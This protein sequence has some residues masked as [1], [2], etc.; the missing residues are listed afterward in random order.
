MVL[1][2]KIITIIILVLLFVIGA[3]TLIVLRLQEDRA[4]KQTLHEA[5]LINTLFVQSIKE[6]M[7]QGRK[8]DV[9]KI[10]LNISEAPEIV[11]LRILSPHGEILKSQNPEELGT[12]SRSFPDD[13]GKMKDTVSFLTRDEV[14]SYRIIMNEPECHGCHDAGRS[15]NGIIEMGIDVSRYRKDMA[16]VR[17]FMIFSGAF[18]VSLVALILSLLLS[19]HIMSPLH[20]LTQAIRSV[21]KGDWNTRVS[22]RSDD[23]MGIIG[24]SFNKMVSEIDRLYN[25]NL[26]KERELLGIKSELDHK[27]KLEHLN[28]Q[29]HF[30]VKELE[31]ANRSI[32][33]LSHELRDKNKELA[34]MV[35]H[36]K[37]INEV[38]RVLNSIIQKDEIVKLIIKT[39][40][41]VLNARSG[42][43]HIDSAGRPSLTLNYKKGIGVEKVQ[44]LSLDFKDTYARIVQDGKHFVVKADATVSADPTEYGKAIGVPLR[45]RGEIVG[46]M[47]IEEKIDGSSFT[48]D[49]IELLS[50]LSRQAM[51]AIENSWLYEKLKYN[52]LS[53]IQALVNALEASDPYT[54]GHSERVRCLAVELS[55]DIGLDQKE[56]DA[57]EHAAILHDIGKIGIET[58]LLNK[59]G[60]LTKEEH[61]QIKTHPVIGEEILGPIE[62][63]KGVRSTIL[64]HHERYDGMGYP[65]GLVGEEITLKARVLAVVDTFD[66]MMTHRPYRGAMS[67]EKTLDEL[68]KE[69][70]SQFDPYIVKS[71]IKILHEKGRELLE[72]AGYDISVGS[73]N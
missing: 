43:I 41:E 44:D 47:L 61:Q 29:L 60:T 8:S 42:V 1:R 27:R 48:E 50:T 5:N 65:F 59:E 73:V 25:K 37:M 3:T 51:V 38:G 7:K 55:N 70:G 4:H 6:A 14:L 19:K 15:I 9:Q 69:A 16:S 26:K 64:Q 46:A 62:T 30:K 17:R 12:R 33:T 52:Y 57:L 66:A 36:L 11:S 21:E 39:S 23:E 24:R 20:R 22:I 13:T 56:V 34:K 45:I 71:F 72:E 10:I 67:Y 68:K 54:K 2:T 35:D 32:I 18:M 31:S 58:T 40:A 53:T 63:L 28:S 49:E